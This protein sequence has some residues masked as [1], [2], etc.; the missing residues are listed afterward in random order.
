MSEPIAA[1]LDYSTA[2]TAKA[3]PTSFV[4]LNPFVLYGFNDQKITELLI[5]QIVFEVGAG[6]AA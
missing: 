3:F 2:V 5:G 4:A 1:D 6:T